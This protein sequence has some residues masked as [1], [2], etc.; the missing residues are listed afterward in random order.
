MLCTFLHC[1]KHEAVVRDCFLILGTFEHQSGGKCGRTC[2][3]PKW[4]ETI[5][6]G[7]KSGDHEPLIGLKAWSV[8]KSTN[9]RTAQGRTM[10]RV[11]EY[12]TDVYSCPEVGPY[13]PGLGPFSSWV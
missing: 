13:L 11:P 10:K 9:A 12:V 2:V 5:H 8:I 4:Y 1:G 7:A 6:L 3:E